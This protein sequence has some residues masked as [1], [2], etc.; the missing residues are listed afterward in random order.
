MPWSTFQPNFISNEL[1]FSNRDI[2][3]AAEDRSTKLDSQF[4]A[5]QEEVVAFCPCACCRPAWPGP[6][7]ATLTKE[8]VGSTL[9]LFLRV[10]LK[11]EM[12]EVLPL[13]D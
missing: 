10:L 11:R 8:A 4:F 6:Q 3:I 1:V 7:K 9:L 5:K 2:S 13:I 12:S